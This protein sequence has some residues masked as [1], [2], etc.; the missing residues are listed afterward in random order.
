MDAGRIST[1]H[2][3][4]VFDRS[5]IAFPKFNRYPDAQVFPHDVIGGA[6]IQIDAPS[7]SV[8]EPI[9]LNDDRILGI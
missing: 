6:V 4:I 8:T 5:V 1:I 9:A 2:E 7:F 3:N